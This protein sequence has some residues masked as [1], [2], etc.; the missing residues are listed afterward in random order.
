MTGIDL[1]GN[2][3][4]MLIRS[5]ESD[6]LGK[7]EAIE[8]TCIVVAGDFCPIKRTEKAILSGKA[9]GMVE[10]IAP[11]LESS[12]ISILILR[13]HLRSPKQPSKKQVRI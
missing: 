6:A 13:R 7:S 5:L 9:A 10:S 4:G 11:I 12:D 1:K 2:G 3:A 8:S